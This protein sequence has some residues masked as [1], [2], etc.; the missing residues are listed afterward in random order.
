MKSFSIGCILALVLMAGVAIASSTPVDYS[1]TWDLDKS[2]SDGLPRQLQNV[3]I[4]TLTVTQDD[5]QLTVDHKIVAAPRGADDQAGS[6]EPGGR[7]RQD[8]GQAG[9]QSS[10]Q[11]VGNGRRGGF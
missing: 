3:E 8:A 11:G 6:G 10:G 1:G 2:K 4:Y 7:R 9:G 5:K